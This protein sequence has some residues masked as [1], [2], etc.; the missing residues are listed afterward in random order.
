MYCN[1]NVN[2]YNF[3]KCVI[4]RHN[5]LKYPLSVYSIKF[6]YSAVQCKVDLCR[7]TSKSLLL[8]L[9]LVEKICLGLTDKKQTI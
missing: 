4:S 1:N 3:I 5:D 7:N 6:F 9:Q 8:H 2:A